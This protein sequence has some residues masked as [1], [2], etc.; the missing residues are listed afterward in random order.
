MASPNTQR[1]VLPLVM[2]VLMAI[3]TTQGRYPIEVIAQG[4]LED[5]S[6]PKEIA[7]VSSIYQGKEYSTLTPF[8]MKDGQKSIQLGFP[9]LPDNIQPEM[10][11][12]E[13]RTITMNFEGNPIQ[14]NA[15]LTDYD[16]DIPV[17][18]P[19]E[20]TSKNTFR[21]TPD[22]IKTLEVQAAF[23]GNKQVF[24]NTLVNVVK[25]SSQ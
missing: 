14:V 2:I 22:G 8:F 3:I 13:G 21:V 23:P 17:R 11:V 15:F 25:I 1:I 24:Y 10:T 18:Y 6:M 20:E 16:A 19:L 5:K 4:E 9:K 12:E 7:K